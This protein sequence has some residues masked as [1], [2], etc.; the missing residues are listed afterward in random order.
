MSIRAAYED[1][2]QE[3]MKRETQLLEDIDARK[4]E[5]KGCFSFLQMILCE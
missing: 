3:T 5:R 4:E 2:Q 1:Y